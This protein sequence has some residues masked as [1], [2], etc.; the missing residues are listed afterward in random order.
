MSNNTLHGLRVLNTRPLEQGLSL[1][2]AIDEAGGISIV[3]P[4]LTIE[5]TTD[6]WLKNLPD[7]NN[8]H[9]MV[10]IFIS[11]NAINYFYASLAEK[12]LNW[13]TTIQTIAIGKA[14]AGALIKWNIHIDRIPTVADSEHLLEL[15]LL[16][17]IKNKTI[18]LVKGEG[19]LE[20]IASTLLQRGAHLISLEVYR[21]TLPQT[22]RQ[23]AFSLWQ[24][25]AVD[26]ILFTSQQA[27][28]NIFTL[29]G[30]DAHLWLCNKPCLVI[31]E[32]L[33]HAASLLGMQT[34][35]VSRHDAI[36]SSLNDY[37]KERAQKKNLLAPQQR[38][39][40]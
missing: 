14:C 11:A 28:Q 21:R 30:K 31:S 17:N 4:L 37:M 36:L 38:T 25:D 6:N 35:I 32:R 8:R 3:L 26:I 23:K 39:D 34:I 5:P 9:Q 10:F 12:K 7:L 27:M 15:D 1:S 20:N 18:V 16:Q 33:A 2:L 24:D 22:G 40:S 13:P 19:G 29:F